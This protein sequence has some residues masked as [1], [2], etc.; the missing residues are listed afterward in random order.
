[1]PKWCWSFAEMA[2]SKV[3]SYGDAGTKPPLVATSFR[4]GKQG[5]LLP[6]SVFLPQAKSSPLV[7]TRPWRDPSSTCQVF[8]HSIVYLQSILFHYELN[9]SITKK[10][11]VKKK[12]KKHERQ[13]T[14]MPAGASNR[15]RTKAVSVRH[16]FFNPFVE[17]NKVNR[18]WNQIIHRKHYSDLKK[19]GYFYLDI[20]TDCCP[21]SGSWL[22]L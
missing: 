10:D 7:W 12:Q 15:P 8:I 18:W 14:F 21:V 3:L 22:Y 19:C 5:A 11:K 13:L 2:R 9:V 1:M 16:L 17:H 20:Y 6:I 4:F